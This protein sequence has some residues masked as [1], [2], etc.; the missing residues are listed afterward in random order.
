MARWT[1]GQDV[2]RDEILT[3]YYE[4][5]A[6]VVAG[7]ATR[8]GPDRAATEELWIT[9]VETEA[10]I[11]HAGFALIG[12]G[13]GFWKIDGAEYLLQNRASLGWSLLVQGAEIPQ[14][15]T[16]QQRRLLRL[17]RMGYQDFLDYV[18]DE[19]AGVISTKSPNDIGREFCL[20]LADGVVIEIG[21]VL[22]GNTSAQHDWTPLSGRVD[23]LGAQTVVD[24]EGRTR[25]WI[26]D[27]PNSL[28]AA[29]GGTGG[30]A[31]VMLEEGRCLGEQSPYDFLAVTE[32][33][34]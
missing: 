6:P 23:P 2:S 17:A 27:L 5:T 20:S 9:A 16:T 32:R 26:A 10:Q 19:Y 12:G 24:A 21:T 33:W 11:E 4:L 29:A 22:V 8:Y 1:A 13:Y 3:S 30:P 7:W 25:Y 28:Y 18:G 34:H 31:F 14:K 15:P